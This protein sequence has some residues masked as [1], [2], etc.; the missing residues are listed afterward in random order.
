MG[1]YKTLR[2]PSTLVRLLLL[3]A[4]ACC[5]IQFAHALT[6]YEMV[7]E[8]RKSLQFFANASMS[9][10]VESEAAWRNVPGA[11]PEP[12]TAKVVDHWRV[13][14]DQQRSGLERHRE[15]PAGSSRIRTV[16]REG[17][18]QVF[19]F[20]PVASGDANVLGQ[21]VIRGQGIGAPYFRSPLLEYT[22]RILMMPGR[23]PMDFDQLDVADEQEQIDGHACHK[24][25]GTWNGRDF[26]LWLDSAFG[27]LP[28]QYTIQS[29]FSREGPNRRGFGT[30]PQDR[31]VLA[32]PVENSTLEQALTSEEHLSSVVLES[33]GGRN[34]IASAI[35]EKTQSFPDGISYTE[36]QLIK[37]DSIA[38]QP[39]PDVEAFVNFKGLLRDGTPV[40]ERLGGGPFGPEA[41]N[42]FVL[43]DG[44]MV[45]SS[46]P[47]GAYI[48][49]LWRD[50]YRLATD[51][52]IENLRRVDSKFLIAFCAIAALA[53][54]G[55]MAYAA[56]RRKKANSG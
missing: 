54:N 55:A 9:Q 53:I 50:L 40:E 8:M 17:G 46:A 22:D 31:R 34:Y 51:F 42:Y 21:L 45:P 6:A 5:P 14:T 2:T 47:K 7:D 33:A 3:V 24:V 11:K 16:Y 29:D 1:N 49:D 13:M 48:A 52:N 10:T 25:H 56:H 4:G 20:D 36:R 30:R 28:R 23:M 35:L 38:L 15:S 44:Q 39:D 18:R 27:Y 43:K 12:Y 41:I 32:P 37:T 26:T 19:E